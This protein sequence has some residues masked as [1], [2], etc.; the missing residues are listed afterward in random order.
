M[1]FAIFS[2]TMWL[3]SF[4]GAHSHL[5]QV[6]DHHCQLNC[7][8]GTEM[9]HLGKRGVGNCSNVILRAVQNWWVMM[10][11]LMVADRRGFEHVLRVSDK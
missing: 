10:G 11:Q 2:A 5:A 7:C 6:A 1:A 8:E 3:I 9:D 4:F